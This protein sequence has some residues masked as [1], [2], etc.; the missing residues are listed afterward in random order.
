LDFLNP[1]SVKKIKQLLAMLA[2]QMCV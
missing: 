2:I 1:S